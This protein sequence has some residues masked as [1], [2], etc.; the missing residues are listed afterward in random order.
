[1]TTMTQ[2][3]PRHTA[4]PRNVPITLVASHLGRAVGGDRRHAEEFVDIF[5]DVA[6]R[7][8]MTLP[9][10]TPVE[11][12]AR[13]S[14]DAFLAYIRDAVALHTTSEA[15]VAT[16]VIEQVLVKHYRHRVWISCSWL[17]G[18]RLHTEQGPMVLTGRTCPTCQGP[19]AH[20][21]GGGVR[22]ADVRGCGWW[23]CA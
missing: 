22:C 18:E 16:A 15:R 20:G 2:T 7:L 21:T 23:Y 1:M 4:G 9:P 5:V 13:E 8:G 12:L 19:Q 10:Y 17:A 6:A 11:Q 3:L 14:L